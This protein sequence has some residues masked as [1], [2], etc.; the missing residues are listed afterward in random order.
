[1]CAMIWKASGLLLLAGSLIVPAEAQPYPARP[2]TMIVPYAAGG[3]TNIIA[4]LTA[5]GLTVGLGQSFIVENRAGGGGMIGVQRAARATPDG[6]TLLFS[7]TGPVTISP[8]LFKQ[9]GFD[10]VAE[11]EPIVRV[12]SSPAVLL[13]RKNLPVKTVE[14]LIALSKKSSGSLNMA[15]A[16]LGSLQHLIGE[17]FQSKTEVKWTHVPFK[18]SAPAFGELIAER[19]DVMVDVLPA[20]APLVQGG[21]V[22]A[23]AVMAPKRS[24]QL[25]DVPTLEEL[26]FKGFDF[27][28]WH[29]VFAPKGTPANV[30]TKINAAVNA[31]IQKPETQAQLEKMGANADGGTAAQLGER[32]RNELREWGEVIH[33]VE[34]VPEGN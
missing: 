5:Q 20:A 3:A 27:S 28:G 34:I 15:S 7:S 33:N 25:A 18:G 24:R 11:L 23:L 21:Q 2:V 4:R 26:G 9:L 32:M 30:V 19:V 14:E 29:A 22:R 1:M 13:V 17:L 16:G 31:F 12:A 8:L 6:Y 10:P